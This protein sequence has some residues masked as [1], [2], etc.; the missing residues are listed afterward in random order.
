MLRLIATLSVLATAAAGCGGPTDVVPRVTGHVALYDEL[1]N[2][3]PSAGLVQ[4]AALSISSI[5]RYATLTDASGWFDLELPG[6]EAAPL[7]FS[8]D[9]YGDMY[10]FDVE[11][12]ADPIHVGLFARS[13]AAVTSVEARAEPC[14]TTTCLQL[15]LEVDDFFIPGASRRVFRLFLGTDAGVSDIDY[16]F[17]D[18]LLVPNDQLGLVQVGAAVTFELDGLTGLLGGFEPGTM[19]HVLIHGATENLANSY[20]EPGT[21]L[22]IFTDLS[23][24]SARASFVIP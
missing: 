10:R 2:Q 18:L 24:V 19:V 22:E 7:Q 13:S 16:A 17:T 3:L 11:G 6:G 21:G 14:G 8:R 1:G 20:E 12:N 15:A 23:S 4:V 5:R 9:G